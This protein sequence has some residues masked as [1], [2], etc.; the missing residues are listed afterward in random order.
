[1][2]DRE[3]LIEAVARTLQ[4]RYEETG[5]GDIRAWDDDALTDKDRGTYRADAGAVLTEVPAAVAVRVFAARLSS[6]EWEAMVNRARLASAP[7]RRTAMSEIRAALRAALVP[8]AAG[9]R[10]WREAQADED[11]E[12]SLGVIPFNEAYAASQEN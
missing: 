6:E 5:D 9:R 8:R 7:V 3:R 2:S 4:R 10:S 12:R 11:Y 1:M